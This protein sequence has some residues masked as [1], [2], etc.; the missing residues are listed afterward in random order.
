MCYGANDGVATMFTESYN[1]PDMFSTIN[2]HDLYFKSKYFGIL[3]II[4][5][6]CTFY[7]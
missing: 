4:L 3:V 6:F 5:V 1:G 7:A 2:M